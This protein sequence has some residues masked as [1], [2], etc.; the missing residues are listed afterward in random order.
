[1]TVGE[2]LAASGLPLAE[3]RALLA[4]AQGVRREMLVAYP[5]RVVA[6]D[7][8]ERFAELTRRRRAGEPLAY[9]L[10][11]R[12]FYGREF[13]VGPAVLI[14]R[15]ET[16]LLVELTLAALPSTSFPRQRESSDLGR[17]RWI[18]AAEGMTEAS[19]LDLGTGSGCIAITLALQAPQARVTAVECSAAAIAL[20]RGNAQRLG[21]AVEFIEGDWYAPLAAGRRFEAI[22]ANPPYVAAGDRHLSEGDLRYEPAL[23]LTDGG[24]GLACL[25]AVVAGAPAH[26]S[27]G[28]WLG[29]EHGYAQAAAVRE[30]FAAAGLHAVASARDAAGIERV[31]HG[32]AGLTPV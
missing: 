6:D 17:R 11:R 23:A 15:P 10:G 7:A 14:P 30:L 31:T 19:I 2:W 5:E 3:A 18:P 28:G 29:V 22:V 26:L 4:A 1:M 8:G 24:D 12:E 27:P 20:A 13:A 25:R 16:E 32:R 9:L 21:A